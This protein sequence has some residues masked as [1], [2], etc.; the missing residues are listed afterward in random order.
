MHKANFHKDVDYSFIS[1]QEKKLKASR[2][3]YTIF[4]L[5]KNVGLTDQ[6][7]FNWAKKLNYTGYEGFAPDSIVRNNIYRWNDIAVK[8]VTGGVRCNVDDIR[9][10]SDELLC[11]EVGCK[12]TSSWG[13]AG[14]SATKCKNHKLDGM[15]KLLCKKIC[16]WGFE[17]GKPT[18]CER[19]KTDGMKKVVEERLIKKT[20]EDGE[21]KGKYYFDETFARKVFPF[22]N[23]APSPSELV[24]LDKIDISDNF[25]E[26][27]I[28]TD[29]DNSLDNIMDESFF[30]S[31]NFGIVN[32]MS[33]NVKKQNGVG[34]EM[35]IETNT[36][37]DGGEKKNITATSIPN[38]SSSKIVG[39]SSLFLEQPMYESSQIGS[40]PQSQQQLYNLMLL[41]HQKQ[42]Q[43][44]Q[45]RYQQNLLQQ[46]ALMY[47]TM[48]PFYGFGNNL[49]SCPMYTP[50][51]PF[52]PMNMAPGLGLGLGMNYPGYSMF[53]PLQNTLQNSVQSFPGQLGN[54]GVPLANNVVPMLGSSPGNS[55]SAITDNSLQKLDLDLTAEKT[56]DD[57][58][59]DI[60]K[61]DANVSVPIE[62]DLQFG[63]L[64]S[65]V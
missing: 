64:F 26:Q 40:Q 45:Q 22:Q 5:A 12:T 21:S 11:T 10:D 52:L 56:F 46:Q 50:F 54:F 65:D 34:N 25:L 60:D 32:D 49:L 27:D 17:D 7:V 15:K 1:E 53:N 43:Q 59:R 47:N 2:E 41:Q 28:F 31:E 30:S 44:E 4:Y 19:H 6:E 38:E 55:G 20:K 39:S 48:S 33:P 37:N 23:L 9:T 57:L 16:S 14:E 24:I 29:F 51:N 3:L 18:R 62:R 58:M 35:T 13:F 36:D 8:A 61:Y 42:Q 63:D